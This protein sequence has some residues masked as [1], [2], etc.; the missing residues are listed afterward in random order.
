MSFMGQEKHCTLCPRRCGTRPGFCGAPD[1]LQVSAICLHRGE[2]PPVAG[3]KGIVNVFFSHCNLH[4][5]YCQNEA[6]SGHRVDESLVHFHSVESVADRV[7]ELLPQSSGLL[8]FVTAAQYADYIPA[9]MDNLAARGL[10]PTVVYNSSGY[11]SVETLRNLEGIVDIYLPDFKYAD[12]KIAQAYSH[13]ADYP[14]VAAKALAEMVRQV[15]CGLKIDSDGIAYRGLI[16]RHLVL[17]G[18]VDNSLRVLDLL[19]NFQPSAFTFHLSLMAQYFPPVPTLPAPLNRTLTEGE[20]SAVVDHYNELGFF[21]G[22][23]QELSSE[24]HY[25]PDFSN[26]DNP[27]K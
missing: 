11:E 8:G 4:C 21:N 17:P 16:V 5:I 1:E 12:S 23:L 18:H 15:G 13:A 20:Y 2:E 14:E 22:W 3:E 26:K 24:S 19:A 10:H 27:F 6:I 9:I 25:R 7:A